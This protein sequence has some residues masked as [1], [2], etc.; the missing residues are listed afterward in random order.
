[1]FLKCLLL[2]RFLSSVEICKYAQYS[3]G[4]INIQSGCENIAKMIKLQIY[5]LIIKMEAYFQTFTVL[6]RFNREQPFYFYRG[7]IVFL[8]FIFINLLITFN[9]E[10]VDIYKL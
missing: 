3:G 2:V 9:F 10:C 7:N 4:G 5:E 8:N 1:M 6:Q